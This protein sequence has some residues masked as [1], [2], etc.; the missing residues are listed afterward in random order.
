MGLEA[1]RGVKTFSEIAQSYGV[2]PVLVGQWKKEILASAS[3]LFETKRG[4]KS[5]KDNKAEEERLYSE[6]G[7][8]KM[9]V[10]VRGVSREDRMA[11]IGSTD[12]L[13]LSPQCELVEVPRATVYRQQHTAER[14]S[15]SDELL[16][17]RLIDGQ[18][19][20]QPFYGSR[21]MVVFL[22]KQGYVANCKRVQRLMRRLGLSGMAPG[23]A[24]SSKHPEHKIYPYLPRGAAVTRPNQVWT[25]M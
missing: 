18:Y 8:L 25:Q 3:T 16:L 15:D 24:T 12:T 14:K 2:H 17:C 1:V 11:W 9:E 10:K 22:R 20:N 23:L 4:P 21:R 19:T 6:I 13:P 7:R 5:A